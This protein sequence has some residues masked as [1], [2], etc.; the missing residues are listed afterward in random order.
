MS[1]GCRDTGDEICILVVE[2]D[3]LIG[4]GLAMA[5]NIAGYRVV[6]PIGS[7]ERA[8]ARGAAERPEIALVDIDLNGR[9]DGVRV[10]RQLV[11]R[12]GTT[13][14]FVT[15]R[16]ERAREARD[17]A[18]GV[19]TKPYDLAWIPKVIEVARQHRLGMPIGELPRILELFV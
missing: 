2:D 11:E 6:G 9:G 10:A 1:S 15:G 8:L 17:C 4:F 18:L 13:V 19:I 3:L 7:M 14:I 16:P 12:H 5:L